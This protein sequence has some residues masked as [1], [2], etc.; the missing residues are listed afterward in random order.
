MLN[1]RKWIVIGVSLIISN[2]DL[3]ACSRIFWDNEINKIAARTMD[4]YLDEKPTFALKPRGVKKNGGVEQNSAEW[5]SQYGSV[6]ITAFDGK[7]VSEGMNEKGLA[8]HLLYLHG[9]QYESRD[10]RPG[11]ANFLWAEY[12][13]DHYAS[14]KEALSSL[15]TFQVNST[16][17]GGR[18]WPI[19]ACLEDST[20]DSAIIEYI[21]GKIVIHHGSQY[22]VM[23]NEPAYDVQIKNL[24][25][26]KY[27]GGK[28]P[29]PGDIDS[30]SRFV[31][32][33]A[34]LKTLT[35]PNNLEE[36][37]GYLLGVIRTVQVPFGAEDTSNTIS[38]DTW[39]TRWVSAADVTNL[40]YYFNSTSTPNIIWVNLKNL[41]F[42]VNQPIKSIKLHDPLLVGNVSSKF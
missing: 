23:T 40:V 22:T 9:T 4:L 2:F 39:S 19:H 28:L 15:D 25:N 14:V 35:K 18:E 16:K 7:A 38:D 20:G 42:S 27:F 34:F 32:C 17:V 29:L 41:D 13:L 8:V 6:V 21:D 11:V 33:S 24:Q 36:A 31:R 3:E 12:I 26:Y 10:E 37:A 5:V 1:I 30:M